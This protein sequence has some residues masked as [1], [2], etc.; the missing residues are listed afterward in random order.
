MLI[1]NESL[2]YDAMSSLVIW[3]YYLNEIIQMTLCSG[4]VSLLIIVENG[5]I[6][7][8]SLYE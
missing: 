5:P 8:L 7:I 6:E 1:L 3:I 2:K 4:I